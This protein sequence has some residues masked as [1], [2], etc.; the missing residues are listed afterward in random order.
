MIGTPSYIFLKEREK[1]E[2]NYHHQQVW[3]I[4]GLWREMLTSEPLLSYPIISPFAP[5]AGSCPHPQLL[6]LLVFK[7]LLL[8]KILIS[9]S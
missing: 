6:L 7:H 1:K 2:G 3:F 5:F 8:G 9:V 4:V